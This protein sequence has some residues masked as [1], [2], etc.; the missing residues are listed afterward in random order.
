[1]GGDASD[2]ERAPTEFLAVEDSVI[3]RGRDPYF[4]PWPDVAQ[5]NAFDPALRRAAIDTL[6]DI[7]RV[8]DGVRCDMAMLMLNDVFRRTWGDRAGST[9][10]H[11]YWSAVIA[12]VTAVHPEMLFIAEA[13]WD[14]EWQLQQLGF[15]YCYDKRLYDR[16]VHADPAQIRMHLHADVEYQRRLLRFTENHDEP[17]AANDMTPAQSR[18][19]AVA[20]ATLPGATLWHEGQFEGWRV[21]VPV[22]LGRR[23]VEPDDDELRAFHIRLIEAAHAIRTGAWTLCEASGWSDNESCN[24]LLAWAWRYDERRALVVVN[25]ADGP[26]SAKV[27]VPWDDMAGRTWQLEDRLS[28]ASYLR[29]GADMA[30]NGLFIG[31]AAWGAHLFA[32]LP[33]GEAL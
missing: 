10:Q 2:L 7:G 6:V 11:E 29:D 13:Y 16:L 22:L 31:L 20:I 9:P 24:Q 19:A 28:G 12:A 4:P 17:R 27:T 33:V 21:H 1:V 32:W 30:A 8:A 26:A 3:A 23:P 25:Y 5:L 15:D 18:A 14:L